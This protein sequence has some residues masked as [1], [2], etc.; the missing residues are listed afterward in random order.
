[1][2]IT[3]TSVLA[4]PVQQTFNAKLLSVPTPNM[5]MN[6]PS[7]KYRM[8]RNGGTTMRFRRYNPLNTA[9][10]PLGNSGVQSPAQSLT[11]MDIDATISWYG[12]YIALNEQVVL[13][14]QEQVLNEAALRLGVS[15][16]QTEDELTRNMLLGTTSVYDC[17]G[18]SNGDVPSDL[19]SSDVANVTKK[20]LGNNAYMFLSGITGD[21]KFGTAPVRN[22]Y[23]G[24]AHTDLTTD[25]SDISTFIHQSQYPSQ[26]N[27]LDSEWGAVGN[28]RFLVSS[29]G[30]IVPTSS[31]VFG[32][33]V[34]CTF[35]VGR[36]AYGVI[37]QDGATAQFIYRP[38][39]YS[40]PLAQNVTIGYKFAQAT[41]ILNDE[42]LVN[43]RSTLPR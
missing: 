11:S 31:R 23:F 8:P 32:A 14:N 30:A 9:L 10:V 39:Q 5:I 34:Y 3:T 35:V 27:V 6:I 18:G 15:L 26:Q 1:M 36:E 33:D 38:A 21:L 19:T 25:L 42:W 28:V 41:R 20:L 17:T 12:T 4:A 22:A 13:Q 40:D 7:E 24:L 29:I 2:A 43:M 16:R 37:A